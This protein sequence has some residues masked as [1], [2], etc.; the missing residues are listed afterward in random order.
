MT[1][2]IPRPWAILCIVL[3]PGILGFIGAAH[4]SG[5]GMCGFVPLTPTAIALPTFVAVVSVL[6]SRWC[7]VSWVVAPTVYSVP[8]L[9]P[10]GIPATS[11]AE[12]WLRLVIATLCVVATWVGARTLQRRRSLPKESGPTPAIS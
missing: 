7:D 6:L 2:F 11:A 3:F 12:E 9:A 5:I 4:L 1:P 8:M 10:I